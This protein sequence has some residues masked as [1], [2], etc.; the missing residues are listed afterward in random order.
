MLY[1]PV[2][3]GSL[4]SRYADSFRDDR[5]PTGFVI[6]ALTRSMYI[7]KTHRDRSHPM[8]LEKHLE[9]ISAG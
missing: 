6:D 9:E 2:L 1:S 5:C 7:G 3:S 4:Y 8:H